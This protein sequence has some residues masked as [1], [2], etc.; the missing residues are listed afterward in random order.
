MKSLEK[1]GF[2]YFIFFLT[3]IVTAQTHDPVVYQI[4][5]QKQSVNNPSIES[6]SAICHSASFRSQ[7]SITVKKNKLSKEKKLKVQIGIN[8][9]EKNKLFK[10]QNRYQLQ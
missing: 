8:Y 9:N 2:I 1:Q 4:I 3:K 10:V 6:L 7:L 5:K